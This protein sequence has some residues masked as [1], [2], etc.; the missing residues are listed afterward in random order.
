MALKETD[1]AIGLCAIRETEPGHYEEAG[2]C[3]GKMFQGNGYGKEIVSLLLNL[4][5]R[6]LE[7]VDVRYG[8]FQ[9]NMKSRKI[10]EHFGFVYDRSEEIVWPWDG[11]LKKID[12]CILTREK[13]L[14]INLS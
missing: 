9:D 8:Y 12:S 3:I 14:P 4:S 1:E 7:A 11:S 10:A 13:Y 5:F 6:E 2:I